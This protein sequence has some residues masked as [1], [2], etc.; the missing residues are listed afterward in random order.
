LWLERRL[1]L[2]ETR[3]SKIPTIEFF[4]L[5]GFYLLLHQVVPVNAGKKGV[6]HDVL[7]IVLASTQSSERILLQ[8]SAEQLLCIGRNISG[9]F[10]LEME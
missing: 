4:V 6:I 10:N 7:G 9:K 1:N 2:Q 8:E 5:L 3:V